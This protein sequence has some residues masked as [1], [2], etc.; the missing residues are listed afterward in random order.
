MKK[1]RIIPILTVILLIIHVQGFAQLKKDAGSPNISGILNTPRNDFLFGFLDPSK[2]HMNHS[3]SMSY[4]ALGGQGMMLSSYM[5]TIHLQLSDNLSV[6]TNIGLL[7]SPYNTFGENFYLN[8]PKVFGG[9]K[10]KYQFNENS[11]VQLQFN[12]T[13]YYYYQPNIGSYRFNHFE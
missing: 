12:Y 2:I 1:L 9:A 8:D 11:S 5:N 4:N 13:P 3:F 6:Q 10:I 7:S